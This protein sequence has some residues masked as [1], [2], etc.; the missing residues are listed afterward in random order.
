MRTLREVFEISNVYPK[1]SR[2]ETGNR[3]RAKT[4]GKKPGNNPTANSPRTRKSI[5]LGVQRFA[6][7]VIS[8]RAR[9]GARVKYFV[10]HR[11][12]IVV[13]VV[14]LARIVVAP[15]TTTATPP[16]LS[17]AHAAATP[18]FPARP[19]TR[20]SRPFGTGILLFR[21]N[22]RR[23]PLPDC[24]ANGTVRTVGGAVVRASS[25]PANRRRDKKTDRRTVRVSRKTAALR[26]RISFLLVP[27]RIARSD[28][29]RAHYVFMFSTVATLRLTIYSIAQRARTYY[30]YT[31]YCVPA[32]IPDLFTRRCPCFQT[33]FL[34]NRG[35]IS[36]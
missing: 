13:V 19:L 25:V 23:P 15:I 6:G 8:L 36:S 32:A 12:V 27:R 16:L 21:D 2:R 33:K 26:E 31:V 22:R 18:I 10:F 1:H 35:K 9:T 29:G 17:G 14:V 20:S 28:A 3:D 7:F 30:S 5:L 34:L 4:N 24:P 11:P